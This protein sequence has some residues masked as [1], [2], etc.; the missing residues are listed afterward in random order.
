[1]CPDQGLPDH[2]ILD[3][4]GIRKPDGAYAK[5]LMLG[6]W[7]KLKWLW[8]DYDVFFEG[9]GVRPLARALENGVCSSGALKKITM[10]CVDDVGHVSSLMEGLRVNDGANKSTAFL[11]LHQCATS[12]LTEGWFMGDLARG[13]RSGTCPNLRDLRL[14]TILDAEPEDAGRILH[15]LGEALLEGGSPKLQDCE[16]ALG[17]WEHVIT[18]HTAMYVWACVLGGQALCAATLRSLRF[19]GCG[20]DDSHVTI[21]TR[22]LR[23]P[24]AAQLAEFLVDGMGDGALALL[25]QVPNERQGVRLR[26]INMQ[27]VTSLG[28][29]ALV[30]ALEQGAFPL[31]ECRESN[32]MPLVD[33]ASRE[34]LTRQLTVRRG[35]RWLM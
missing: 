32:E 5:C 26:E 23:A 3:V 11:Y 30:D 24:G 6:R 29:Q 7:S 28:A 19:R 34:R 18:D 16:I 31:L 15:A 13:L 8:L 9:S 4:G 17:L 2:M 14:R 20:L 1:M 35:M 25:A 21:L 10:L 12:D 27:R 22:A 33:Q